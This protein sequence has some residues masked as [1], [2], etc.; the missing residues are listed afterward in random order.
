ME[1]CVVYIAVQVFS[2]KENF[3]KKE[4]INIVD[5]YGLKD[6]INFHVFEKNVLKCCANVKKVIR[7]NILPGYIIAEFDKSLF[8]KVVHILSNNKNSVKV[9]YDGFITKDEI[10]RLFEEIQ[11]SEIHIASAS[12]LNQTLHK[13]VRHY[14]K[15]LKTMSSFSKE[16]V[17]KVRS[18]LLKIKNSINKQKVMHLKYL[19]LINSVKGY[20]N[21]ASINKNEVCIVPVSLLN[22]DYVL[23]DTIIRYDKKLISEAFKM[24]NAL[25]N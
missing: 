1:G 20:L 3:I 21:I 18:I 9:L 7:Q 11:E 12:T 19:R 24:L 10:E 14:E 8:N 22:N 17:K 25:L 4:L 15:K 23:R 5:Y 16:Q 13:K 6:K 2:G